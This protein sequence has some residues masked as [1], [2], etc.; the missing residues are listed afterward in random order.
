[1][2]HFI[3]NRLKSSFALLW[4]SIFIMHVTVTILYCACI[5]VITFVIEV[6]YWFEI[7]SEY[8][9]FEFSEYTTEYT[10]VNDPHSSFCSNISPMIQ[11]LRYCSLCKQLFINFI[12]FWRLVVMHVLDLAVGFKACRRWRLFPGHCG[13]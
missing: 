13:C 8:N 3:L 4:F 6:V 12:L 1:M 2:A 7:L 11:S 5:L 10:S 9:V